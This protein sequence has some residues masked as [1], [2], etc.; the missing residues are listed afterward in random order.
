MFGYAGKFLEVDLTAE[1][2]KDVTFNED[3]LRQYIGGRGLAAKILWDRLGDRWE[4]IDP[5]GPE[6][7]LLVLPGPLTGYYPGARICVSGKSPQCNGIVGSTVSCEFPVELKCAGYDG[8]IITGKAAKPSYIFITNSWADIKDAGNLW[9]KGGQETLK[10]LTK[11]GRK[12]L[13]MKNPR[14]GEWKEPSALYIGPAG[15]NRSRMA[16]VIAKRN[17]AAGFGGYGAVMG[18]KNLK[19]ILAKGIGSLPDI[20]DFEKM[21]KLRNEVLVSGFVMNTFRWWGMGGDVYDVGNL[22]S[23]EPVR[24]WQEEWHNIK[25]L[26]INRIEE[27]VHVKHYWGDFGCPK[28]CMRVSMSKTGPF[29]GAIA[30]APVYELQAC[31]GVNLGIFNPEEIVYMVALMDELGLCGI[32]AGN[33]LGF[34]G[35]LY[36]KGILGKEDL[37]G[38]EPVWGNVK[39]FAALARKIAVRD[40]VGEL[41]AEGS[42]RAALK[43]REK[44]GI[45][46][47]QYAI[48]YKGT[49]PGAHG[50]RSG[51]WIKDISYPCSVQPGDH[52]SIAA[53]PYGEL[54]SMFAD[55]G[56]LLLTLL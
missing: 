3:I 16:H 38:I 33:V 43:L 18:S 15:E 37:D 31:V 9:G 21:D 11:E 14:Y 47:M 29:K 10:I 32:Q 49:A 35:E 13:E 27:R 2:L 46:V 26:G 41:F 48:T 12:E 1:K 28:T 8:L 6:N 52:C 7:I 19:A 39:A 55:S 45:D 53:L 20:A 42:Y 56:V 25:I 36:E 40:G 34:I 5:L 24:N 54:R 4:T 17:H 23:R 44:K 22:S 51:T 30:S 50:P